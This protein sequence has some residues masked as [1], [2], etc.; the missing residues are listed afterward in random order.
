M[1]IMRI[2]V[3]Y[4]SILT[5]LNYIVTGKLRRLYFNNCADLSVL[6]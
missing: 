5:L 4:I 2:N 1:E 6:L 3:F